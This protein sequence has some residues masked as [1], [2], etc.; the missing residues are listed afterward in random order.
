MC[1]LFSVS[2]HAAQFDVAFST[3]GLNCTFVLKLEMDE[4]A[5]FEQ[6]LARVIAE[7]NRLPSRVI[8]VLAGA[9]TGVELC[10]VLSERLGTVPTNGTTLSRARRNK[11]IM[12]ETVRKSGTRAVKQ[13]LATTWAEIDQFISE[14]RPD[15]F[16][17]VIKPMESAGSDDVT[18]CG[19]LEELQQAFGNIMGKING[20]GQVNEGVLVQEF[21]EGI[22]YIVD[23]VSHAG[24][25]KL[26]GLW[27]YDR[28]P[29][30]GAGFVCHGQR[31]MTIDEPWAKELFEYQ[32]RVL[33]A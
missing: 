30:N 32:K 7:L 23:C 14:W 22:E 15:P 13:L 24:E 20:I 11:Y 12:G 21:L 18:L 31:L 4:Q 27:E 17:V 29:T 5:P 10:D 3:T 28:R 25:H 2:E 8:G 26:V 16:K 1:S 19:S 33:G 9:E 6:E